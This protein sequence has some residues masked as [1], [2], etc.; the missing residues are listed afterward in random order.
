M[1]LNLIYDIIIYDNIGMPFQGSTPLNGALGGSEFELILLAESLAKIGKKVLVLNNNEFPAFEN[2]VLY[3]PGYFLKEKEFTCQ[4]L[5]I[6]R[7]SKLIND[8]IKFQNLYVFLQDF[9]GP[10]HIAYFEFLQ[11]QYSTTKFITVSDTLKNTL[12]E[13]L[14]IQTIHNML[15][16]W[17]YDVPLK[18]NPNKFIYA[19]ASFKGL[20][21]TVEMWKDFKR[22]PIFKKAEL[23]VCNPG[24]DSVDQELLKKNKIN[25]LGNLPFAQVVNEIASSDSL[26]YVNNIPET[27]CFVAAI[28]NAVKTKNNILCLRGFGALKEVL[29]LDKRIT[30]NPQFFVSNIVNRYNILDLK[31]NVCNYKMSYIFNKWKQVFKYD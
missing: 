18:K 11:K 20:L 7:Y 21:E 23:H 24:Y 5:I 19:S 17:V 2:D 15:P 10:E 1:N 12:P 26:F 16:D 31:E 8:N 9:Y 6:N 3:Y 22:H 29:P 28:A 30:D 14:N 13:T 25:F 4:K 27:F